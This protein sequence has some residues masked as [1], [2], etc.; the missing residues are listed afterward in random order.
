MC[1]ASLHLSRLQFDW[2]N[3]AHSLSSTVQI[4]CARLFHLLVPV[5]FS[6]ILLGMRYF[7]DTW[8]K[9]PCPG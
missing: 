6:I 2:R 1:I 8:T 5:H 4:R 7:W 3:W 9:L